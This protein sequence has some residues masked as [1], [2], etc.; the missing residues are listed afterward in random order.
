MSS[1]DK[2]ITSDLAA[3]GE[4]SRRNPL[5]LDATLETKNAYRDD[6]PGAEA[7]R[8]ALAEDRRRELAMMPLVLSQVFA[9]RIGRAAVGGAAGLATLVMVAMLADPVLLELAEYFVPSLTSVGEIETIAMYGLIGLLIVYVGAV[10]IAEGW[11]A[12]RMRE[13][14]ITSGEPY[15]D[16]DSLARGP[17]E[18]AQQLVRRVDGLAVGLFLGGMTALALTFGYVLAIVDTFDHDVASWTP[19]G[20]LHPEALEKNLPFL[21]LGLAAVAAT[22]TYLGRAAQ[23]QRVSVLQQV[24]ARRWLLTS[25]FVAGATWLDAERTL[26][27]VEIGRR[28]PSTEHRLILVSFAV[29]AVLGITSFLVVWW[30]AR[31]QKRIGDD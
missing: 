14:I 18:G 27:S 11:F 8:D 26:T 7:R 21:V 25:A 24:A 3:L 12:R 22:A 9:H 15:R 19:V 20:V 29:C 1:L 4:D 2:L 30:R 10:W 6:R 31:E 5:S 23:R 16:L 13:S 17:I 28:L